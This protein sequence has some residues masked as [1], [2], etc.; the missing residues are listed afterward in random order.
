MLL[1]LA[2]DAPWRLL[3]LGRW[4][5]AGLALAGGLLLLAGWTAGGVAVL[6]A[7]SG[8][9]VVGAWWMQRSLA[10]SLAH[11]QH[12][13]KALLQ[14]QKMAEI[15]QL[16][17]G[18][19]HEINNPLAIIGQEAELALL[20]LGDEN[21]NGHGADIRDS[22]RQIC[23]QVARGGDITRKLLDFSRPREAFVQAWDLNRLVEDMILLVERDE[24]L[25]DVDVIRS[26]DPTLTSLH[27][28]GPLLRQVLLNLLNNA[29]Q[30]AQ[31]AQATQAT[32][33]VQSGQAPPTRTGHIT[34]TT[35]KTASHAEISVR[36]SGAGILPEHLDKLFTPFFTTKAP[37]QGTGLGLALCKRMVESLGGSIRVHSV[38][39]QGAAFTIQLPLDVPAGRAL[40]EAPRHG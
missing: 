36:D 31:A 17:S 12:L 13:D 9:A 4:T 22:L 25:I 7:G 11:A 3:R 20:L 24:R 6:A 35:A 21:P 14:S 2:P 10:R 1:L 23:Q 26:Y 27:T 29:A 34:V 15:G 37:G 16:A 5:T 30:A 18:V 32:Q 38:Y 19:A 33:T 28:D 8:L 39:G 40:H